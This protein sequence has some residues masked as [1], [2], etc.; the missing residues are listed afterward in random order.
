[1]GRHTKL[2][3]D[4][5]QSYDY[6]S[7][8]EIGVGSGVNMAQVMEAC[9]D[10][11]Y[12]GIDP[13]KVYDE[14]KDDINATDI[15]IMRNKIKAERLFKQYAT[16]W[17]YLFENRS[18]DIPEMFDDESIDLVFVDGNHDYEYVK[19]DLQIYW[20][21]IRKGGVM[22]G[23]DYFLDQMFPGVKRAVDEFVEFNNLEPFLT[24]V[25]NTYHFFKN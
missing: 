12:F 11:I 15:R 19:A 16:Q 20:T 24:P 17:S 1:M 3:I 21:K 22:I 7:W 2:I 14:Y 10:L 13:F 23:H 9:P 5:I 18:I 25:A 6:K 4:L 8:V